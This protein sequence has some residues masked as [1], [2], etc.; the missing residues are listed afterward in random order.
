MK[1]EMPDFAPKFISNDTNGR[2]DIYKKILSNTITY[3]VGIWTGLGWPSI[4]TVADACEC[5]YEPLSFVKCGEFL[6]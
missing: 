6:D 3:F 2:N 5:G 1:G 4:G